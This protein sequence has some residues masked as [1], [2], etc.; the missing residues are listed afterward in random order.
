MVAGAAFQLILPNFGCALPEPE[1]YQ[2]EAGAGNRPPG[3]TCG[4]RIPSLSPPR[5]ASGTPSRGGPLSGQR[6]SSL[7][8]SSC[9]PSLLARS[10]PVALPTPVVQE[11]VCCDEIFPGNDV[12]A[13]G[14]PDQLP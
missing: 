12:A 4:S 11:Q 2:A 8:P 5:S 13:P 6:G 1:L 3:P 14:L 10:G 9:T 7:E